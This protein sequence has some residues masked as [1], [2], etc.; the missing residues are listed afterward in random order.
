[1]AENIIAGV[2]SGILSGIFLL[3]IERLLIP[4][5]DNNIVTKEPTHII[6][7]ERRILKE[8]IV[9]KSTGSN[10]KDDYALGIWGAIILLLVSI[11]G[12]IK[13]TNLIYFLIIVLSMAIGIMAIGMAVFCVKKGTMFKKELNIMLILNT[14]ALI[15]VPG[16]IWRTITANEERGIDIEKLRKQ[17]EHDK[18]FTLF[19]DV[20]D[21]L[22]LGYQIVGLL[23]VIIY[24]LLVLVSNVYLISLINISFNVKPRKIWEFINQKT[25][26]L[27]S[28]PAT[29]ILIEM[30]F[31]IMSYLMVSGVVLDFINTL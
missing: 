12:Y 18:I 29:L 4:K 8:K 16:L 21:T 23:V 22:F 13:Y 24:I 7:P 26:S 19:N 31:L 30:I 3:L 25:Y 27:A 15:A 2:I 20:S 6:E 11:I 14:F 17:V 1:M 9:F 10:S 28:K 5:N